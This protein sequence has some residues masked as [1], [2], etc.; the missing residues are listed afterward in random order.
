MPTTLISA[1]N[2]FAIKLEPGLEEI[3]ETSKV[4]PA[5]FDTSDNSLEEILDISDQTDNNERSDIVEEENN[6]EEEEEE[7]DEEEG[8]SFYDANAPKVTDS[9]Y[10][11]SQILI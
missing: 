9:E 3:L 2:L 10:R 8:F 6:V 1:D 5:T 7:G 11:T 4:E